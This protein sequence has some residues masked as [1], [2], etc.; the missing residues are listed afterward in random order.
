MET[1]LVAWTSLASSPGFLNS[2]P[3]IGLMRAL[4]N[5]TVPLYRS[6]NIV[7]V[8]ICMYFEVTLQNVNLDECYTTAFLF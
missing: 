5:V 2:I 3:K 4:R 8:Q 7:R 1:V 6:T